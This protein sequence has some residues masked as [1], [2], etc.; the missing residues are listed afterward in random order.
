[1]RERQYGGRKARDGAPP[2]FDIIYLYNYENQPLPDVEV[3]TGFG[4]GINISA[5]YINQEVVD[6]CHRKGMR[7]GVWVR[8]K[9][10]KETEEFYDEMFKIG[11]DFI[12]ADQ[13]LKCMASRSKFLSA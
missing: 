1:M 13:P 6:H 5:N 12:C 2:S 10:F 4:D 11:T 8:A 9:D 3:Y 7:I